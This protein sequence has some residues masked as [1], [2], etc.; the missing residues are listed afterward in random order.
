MT[1]RAIRLIAAISVIA[2]IGILGCVSLEPLPARYLTSRGLVRFDPTAPNLYERANYFMNA[3][4]YHLA[5]RDIKEARRLRPT[6]D[7]TTGYFPARALAA[8]TLA[9]A[10][11]TFD[12]AMTDVG[13]T[14]DRAIRRDLFAYRV[15]RALGLAN[16]AASHLERAGENCATPAH[17]ELRTRIK[18]FQFRIR[19]HFTHA[20]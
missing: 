16:L 5:I 15:N 8:A 12:E 1:G 7:A 2:A 18:A 9:L 17:T 6:C 10:E 11:Q 19:A 3:G 13:A 20:R 14:A 4:A